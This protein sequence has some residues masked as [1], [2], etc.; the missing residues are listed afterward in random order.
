MRHYNTERPHQAWGMR[1]RRSRFHGGRRPDPRA[2]RRARPT[3]AASSGSPRKVVANGVVCV[4]WQ[5]VSVGKHFGGS[6]CN[7]LVTDGAASV[8]GG[9]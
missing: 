1:P 6:A 5:Q 2:G 8:L 7:V 4:G 3:A 9:E